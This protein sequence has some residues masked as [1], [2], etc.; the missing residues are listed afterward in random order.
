MNFYKIIIMSLTIVLPLTQVNGQQTA[1]NLQTEITFNAG[2]AIPF[3]KYTMIADKSDDRSAANLGGYG[4]LGCSIRPMKESPFRLATRIGYLHN[5]YKLDAQE[6][7][8]L[9]AFEASD[10]QM[11]YALLGLTYR[12]ATRFF[13]GIEFY[14]GILAY[15]GGDMTVQTLNHKGELETYDWQY[16]L[17]VAPAIRGN[18]KLGVHLSRYLSIEAYAGLL[19]AAGLRNGQANY[20]T[21]YD[22]V[23]DSGQEADKHNHWNT[24]NQTTV[25][26][27]TAG[28]GLTYNVV[29]FRG[30]KNTPG[31]IPS[32]RVYSNAR[33]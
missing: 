17:A 25:M 11:G 33:F 22:F 12:T 32:T 16:P 6:Q 28:L 29:P 10:W 15:K 9:H 31:R 21:F 27:I 26:T 14:A 1:N 18:I 13:V 24:Q 8:A 2:T 3:G 23:K 4:E 20:N 30:M 5:P 7:Y 19:G